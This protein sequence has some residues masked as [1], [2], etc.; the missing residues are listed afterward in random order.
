MIAYETMKNSTNSGSISWKS[1]SNIALIKYWGKKGNQLPCN[2][3][4][5]M[6]LK[7]SL[8]ITNLSYGPKDKGD[9]LN[10]LFEGKR[11]ELFEQRIAKFLENLFDHFKFLNDFKISISSEN[12]FPHSTGIASSA[13]AMSALALCLCSMEEDVMGVKMDEASFYQKASTIARLG[14]GS[15]SRSVY[16]GYVAWGQNNSFSKSSDE[17]AVPFSQYIHPVFQDFQDA[18]L[19]VSSKKKGVSS[20]VGHQLM[21]NH[22]YA[23][24]RFD[25]A[26]AH[27]ERMLGVLRSGDLGEFIEIME[28]EAL[29]LH[30]LMMNSIPSYT[31]LKPN[32]LEVIERIR[33]FRLNTKIPVGFTLDAGPNIHLMYPKSE[34]EKVV[35]FI[36]LDLSQFLENGKYIVDEKGDGPQ[37]IKI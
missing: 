30:G 19:L 29:S 31:L 16:G 12:T 9:S 10:F 33:A 22:P 34:K 26:N 11:Q 36:A 24:A 28:N 17:Y 35:P 14:S 5:S 20:S 18:I 6:S 25:Q 2:P 37:K 23:T 4:I 21:K 1:P 3:S 7:N 32:T 27:F 15:A 13:S 8:S